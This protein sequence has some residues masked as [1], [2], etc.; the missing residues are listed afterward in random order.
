MRLLMRKALTHFR[1]LCLLF[2]LLFFSA[3]CSFAKETTIH[4]LDAGEGDAILI[5][6]PNKKH[7]L[8]DTGTLITG[9]RIIKLLQSCG[10]TELQHLIL[11]HPHPDHIGGAFPAF[12]YLSIQSVFDN[13]Q[14]ILN[15]NESIY[16]WYQ[17]LVRSHHHYSTLHKGE[18]LTLD[19]E[20]SLESLWPP[21]QQLSD[22]WNTNSLVLKIKAH[23]TEILL[24]GDANFDTEKA[25]LRSAEQKLNAHI[26]KAGHHG[27][28]RTGS[29]EFI[30]AVKPQ[31]VVISV[32][33]NNYWGYPD[34]DTLRR[35][36]ASGATLR[37]TSKFGNLAVIISDKSYTISEHAK[38][39]SQ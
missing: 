9:P 36:S 32:N 10:I 31:Q 19:Q 2:L 38:L 22:D 5:S 15:L 4:F 7:T 6:T 8:I 33:S 20:V 29:P 18:R 27:S 3:P 34:A 1:A 23:E 25:L 21:K 14:P 28:A 24:M 39:C 17:E 13:G 11:T 30:K 16:R 12:A 37:Q 35:Y 26:L